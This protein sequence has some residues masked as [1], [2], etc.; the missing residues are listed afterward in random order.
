MAEPKIKL[1]YALIIGRFDLWFRPI[2][3][4]KNNQTGT[5]MSCWFDLRDRMHIT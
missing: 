5:W 1:V 2:Q 4:V 3:V